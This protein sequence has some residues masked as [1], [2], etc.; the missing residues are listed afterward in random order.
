MDITKNQIEEITILHTEIKK[1]LASTLQKA[2]RIGELLCEQKNRLEHGQFTS[3]IKDNLPFTDRTA[4]NYMRLYH[5]R[6]KLKTE[7]V[8]VLNEAYSALTGKEKS[9]KDMVEQE[10]LE[11]QDVWHLIKENQQIEALIELGKIIENS[12]IRNVLYKKISKIEKIEDQQ[13]QIKAWR[14]FIPLAR[15]A[16]QIKASLSLYTEILLGYFLQA[17]IKKNY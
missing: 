16:S 12:K 2:I 8:S 10:E 3:W 6:D 5:E 4:R 7:N 9:F 1:D 11:A 13:E 17:Q 15:K 14:D